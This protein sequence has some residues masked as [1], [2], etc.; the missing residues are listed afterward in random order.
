MASLVFNRNASMLLGPGL[1][2]PRFRKD[3]RLNFDANLSREPD[4]LLA[5]G[6]GGN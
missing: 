2:D 6:G 3:E 4:R 5:G 1:S